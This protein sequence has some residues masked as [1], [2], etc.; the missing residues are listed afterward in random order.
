MTRKNRAL[1]KQSGSDRADLR[2]RECLSPW[3]LC[4]L[5]QALCFVRNAKVHK[6]HRRSIFGRARAS[7]P[8]QPLQASSHPLFICEGRLTHPSQ[9]HTTK[10]WTSVLRRR[11]DTHARTHQQFL[12]R[13]GRSNTR[14]AECERATL[15]V[16]GRHS[17][18]DIQTLRRILDN[19]DRMTSVSSEVNIRSM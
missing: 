14:E 2:E 6:S 7:H 13:R 3:L 5:S 4:R 1:K 15:Q 18:S 11:A 10:T 17:D 19:S 8:R 16:I 12:R 9:L